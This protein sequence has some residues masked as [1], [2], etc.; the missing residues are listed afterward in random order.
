MLMEKIFYRAYGVKGNF[1]PQGGHLQGAGA[2]WRPNSKW[3]RQMALN[4]Q[5][6][7]DFYLG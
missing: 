3:Q 4:V 7:V 6:T 1:R 2:R 5:Y